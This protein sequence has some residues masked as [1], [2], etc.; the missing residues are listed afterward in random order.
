MR[1]VRSFETSAINNPATQRNNEKT[2]M[3]NINTVETS[4]L[5]S[6]LIYTLIIR[7]KLNI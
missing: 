1:A 3:L 5:A 4:N 7:V 6:L 2:Q